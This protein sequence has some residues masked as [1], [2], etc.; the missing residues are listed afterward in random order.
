M[1]PKR[2]LGTGVDWSAD[3]ETVAGAARIVARD[4]EAPNQYQPPESF[5]VLFTPEQKAF[6]LSGWGGV[7]WNEVD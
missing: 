6:I 7:K 4:L 1:P 3:P 2:D 5:D